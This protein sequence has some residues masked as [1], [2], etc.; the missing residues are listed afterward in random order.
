MDKKKKIKLRKYIVYSL[1]MAIVFGFVS[2]FIERSIPNN[3][4]IFDWQVFMY[5]LFTAIFILLLI[6]FFPKFK[7]SGD[8]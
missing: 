4:E 1:I 3:N 5:W 8:V 7:K 2:R 6:T